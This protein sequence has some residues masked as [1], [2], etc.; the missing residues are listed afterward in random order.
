MEEEKKQGLS[1]RAFLGLG[2]TALAGAAVAGL[3]GCAPQGSADA[4]KA[5][6]AGAA[7][8]ATGGMPVADSGA[9]AGPDVAGM[10]SW[11]IAPEDIPADKITNTEDC[12]VLVVGAGL[13]GCCATIAALEEGAK[14][15]ITIDKNPETVVARGVHIAGFHTKVQQGLVDQGLVEEPDYNNVVRRW[16]NWAQGRVKEPLLWE[17]ARK[18]G[19]CFDWLY[20]LATKKNLEALL[21]DGY[22]KGPDY[23]E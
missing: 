12:D 4:G 8:G 14:K 2:G 13:G 3:A 10:H 1:R 17:F 15:V 20:D 21:W 11:E 7:D 19:A 16:I 18:S 23:T 9:S 22:Y 5:S 6:T